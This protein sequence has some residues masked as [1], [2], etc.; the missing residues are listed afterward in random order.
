MKLF[1]YLIFCICL[2]LISCKPSEEKSTA[3]GQRAYRTEQVSLGKSIYTQNCLECHGT[4]AQ[5]EPNW[6]TPLADGR[7]PAPPLNGTG[8]AWHHPLADLIQTVKQGSQ[9]QGGRMPAFEK[10][11]SESEIE[12]VLAYIQ[13]LWSDDIYKIWQEK[14]N[15]SATS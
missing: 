14:V 9:S 4:Q 2:S 5:G 13:S 3:T 1:I 7:F 11:L 10:K 15:V 12:Q 8:H 6:K